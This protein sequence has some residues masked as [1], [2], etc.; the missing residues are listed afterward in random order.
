[1]TTASWRLLVTEPADGATNMAIDE[2][3]WRSRQTGAA[4]PTVRFFAWAPPTVSL[5]YGQPLDAAVDVGACRRLGVGV[6]RR[7][8]GGSAIYHDGPERELTYS[9]VADNADLGTPADLLATYNWI[10]RALCRGLRALGAKA[11]M[12]PIPDAEGPVPAFCFARTGRYEIEVA[13]RK[14][15][16]SAQR[17][18]GACFL[19]HGSVLLG[20]D[21]PRLRVIF[22]TT[23]DPLATMTTLEAALGHRPKFEDVAAALTDAFAEEHGLMLRPDGLTDAEAQRVEALVRDKYA[24]DAWLA[25]AE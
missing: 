9:V 15:V 10:A 1:M 17:R 22:P 20:V 24:T 7:P 8:T 12:V 23:T 13:G 4:A 19:Q 6:V 5:G 3:L 14:L 21:A 25:G 2:A 11:E 18:Q 16:G